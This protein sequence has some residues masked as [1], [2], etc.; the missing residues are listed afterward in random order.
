M[1][2]L[3]KSFCA[4]AAIVAGLLSGQLDAQAQSNWPSAKPI[5]IVQPFA[6]G[7]DYL[8]R[9]IAAALEPAPEPAEEPAPAL[10]EDTPAV[11][12]ESS[13][14][15]VEEPTRI[16]LPATESADFSI[17]PAPEEDAAPSSAAS[18]E[19]A[20]EGKPAAETAEPPQEE[21]AFP[22]ISPPEESAEEPPPP[23]PPAPE[24]PKPEPARKGV[25][26]FSWKK[27]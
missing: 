21:D 26:R 14:G 25:T 19:A 24:P 5:T 17:D 22:L 27:T 1:K 12:E 9:L 2:Y 16:D 18:W 20:P 23:P 6:A 8:A 10:L 11:L 3:R 13:E 15:R 7:S 4:A